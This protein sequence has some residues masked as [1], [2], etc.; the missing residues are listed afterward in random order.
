MK[1]KY[2]LHGGYE[3]EDNSQNGEFFTE[4]FADTPEKP[5]ALIVMFARENDGDT[6]KYEN[7]CRLMS[8]FTDKDVK[9][10]K[11]NR[12]TFEAQINQADIIFFQGG[13]TNMLLEKLKKYSDL[14]DALKGKTVVGSSAGAYALST[15]G[16]SHHEA[17][18]REG[19][20][21]LPLRVVCH[22][23][24]DRLAPSK[25][26]LTE[27]RNTR[28]DLELILLRDYEYRVFEK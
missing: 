18:T 25:T 10:K 4:C 28:E 16:A 23:E 2:I 20:G 19:L 3:N 6:E 17:H 1:T 13:N 21:I 14:P 27:I 22:Y 15:L 9:F 24:S 8:K 7:R 26:S 12:E 5:T 11:A